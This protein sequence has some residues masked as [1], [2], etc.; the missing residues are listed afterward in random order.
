VSTADG[1]AATLFTGQTTIV[2]GST[3]QVGL[4]TQ[5]YVAVHPARLDLLLSALFSEIV[6]NK[7]DELEAFTGIVTN[8]D[9][10]ARLQVPKGQGVV[11]VTRSGTNLAARAAGLLLEAR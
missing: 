8:L 7:H 4:E 11:L 5:F 2:E 1:I 10:A 6:T 3:N 9:I